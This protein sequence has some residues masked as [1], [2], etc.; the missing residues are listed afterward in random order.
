M[1]WHAVALELFLNFKFACYLSNSAPNP[2]LS[3]GQIYLQ[4]ICHR[5]F[6]YLK[7]TPLPSHQ[8]AYLKD[9]SK[10]QISPN[11][12]LSSSRIIILFHEFQWSTCLLHSLNLLH[13]LAT[14]QLPFY[15]SGLNVSGQ[16]SGQVLNW[17]SFVSSTTLLVCTKWRLL[18]HCNLLDLRYVLML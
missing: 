3:H 14:S 17:S 12:F 1:I 6:L 7:K 13:S 8:T 10:I 2:C 4:Y 11:A 9:S 16:C 5:V 18:P 15:L